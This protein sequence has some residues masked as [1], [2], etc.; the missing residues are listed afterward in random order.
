MSMLHPEVI[1]L[2]DKVTPTFFPEHQKAIYHR[3]LT[4]HS[5]VEIDESDPLGTRS[6]RRAGRAE[7]R[8]RHRAR[9]VE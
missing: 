9:V 1:K 3:L 8:G 2:E 6:G 5:S 4:K 7:D